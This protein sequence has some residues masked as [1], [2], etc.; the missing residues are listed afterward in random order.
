MN[1]RQAGEDVCLG[2]EPPPHRA[3]FASPFSC[4]GDAHVPDADRRGLGSAKDCP[5]L[6][7]TPNETAKA[8]R[9]PKGRRRRPGAPPTPMRC[10]A[11]RKPTELPTPTSMPARRKLSLRAAN[12][13]KIHA[14]KAA[15]YAA[16]R[17][18][19]VP[20][21]RPVRREEVAPMTP[22]RHRR[23]KVF[24]PGPRVPLD[25][26]AKV[27]VMAYAKAWNARHRQ[28]GQHRGPLTRATIPVRWRNPGFWFDHGM[29]APFQPACWPIDG[30]TRY[31]PR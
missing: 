4:H 17:E 14:Q 29:E 24:G 18:R 21:A 19:I 22:R 6:T 31:G 1:I 12:A 20:P 8:D 26:E 27:R 28:P 5:C 30:E 13:D 3:R 15:Y 11:A 7:D 2:T 9:S 16:N 23:D 25:R 10:K